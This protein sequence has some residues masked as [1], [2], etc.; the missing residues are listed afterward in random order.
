MP[1]NPKYEGPERRDTSPAGRARRA[2]F[3][4]SLQVLVAL[5]LSA[6]TV[7]YYRRLARKKR[8]LPHLLIRALAEN[9]ASL[10]M[11]VFGKVGL[12]PTRPTSAS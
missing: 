5:E 7:E 3:E 1:H 8:T 11:V 4:A 12:D 10:E 9:I 6:G 2:Q